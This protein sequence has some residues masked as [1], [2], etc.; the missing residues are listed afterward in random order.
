MAGVAALGALARP[1]PLPVLQPK[2]Q[3]QVLA[4]TGG[5]VLISLMRAAVCPPFLP[6]RPR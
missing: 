5:W 6:L 2:W 3:V 1:L 4:G